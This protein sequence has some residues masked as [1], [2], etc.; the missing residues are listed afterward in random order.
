MSEIPVPEKIEV[1]AGS[2]VTLT[3][4]D[5]SV[6]VLSAPQLRAACQCASCREPAGEEATR[7]VLGGLEPVTI[8]EAGLVGGYAINFVFGPDGHGTGIFPFVELRAL[9]TTE[10]DSRE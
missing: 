10:P 3:W 6:S 2:T 4:E 8:R 5:G 1:E 9:A 7:L